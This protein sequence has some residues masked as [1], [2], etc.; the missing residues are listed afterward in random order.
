MSGE[1]TELP[2]PKKL[3]DARQKG[4]VAKSQEVVSS[5]LILALIA[6][7]FAFADYYMLHISALLLLPSE[8]AYQGFQDALLDVAI[9]IAKEMVYLLAPILIVAALI[10]IMSNMGQFGLLFSGESV[11]P[12]IKKINPVEGAKRIFSLNSII[13]FIKSIL[14]VSLLSCIIWVT[15]R[16]NLNTLLQ[17]PA[18]GLE[19]V[20]TI[21]SVLVKQ[22]MIISSVGFIVIAAADYAYQK[23]DHTKQLKMTKDEVKREYKEM[24]GSPEIKS[25][26]RQLHQELQASNQR[27]NVKRSSVLVTNP[28]H[29]A[30][31]LYYKKGETPLPVITLKET[32][33]MAKRMIAIAHEEG[34]PVMQKVPLARALY[35]DGQL[36]QYIPGDL[37]ETTAEILRWVASLEQ[38]EESRV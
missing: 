20:P 22:L 16:D 19:C 26:R 23:F 18:C 2:T 30:I 9:A 37:I 31:G 34:V 1:K 4:Q 14:K 24:E 5:A 33:A 10:A 3:R 13:E 25:K 15:L 35:A 36:N 21:T 32:D 7:L 11:K 27:D 8:L 12:D 6:V 29:I 17:I 38:S 28:T